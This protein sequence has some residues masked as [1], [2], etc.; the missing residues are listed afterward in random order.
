LLWFYL[1]AP[2]LPIIAG[3][4]AR[5]AGFAWA[6]SNWVL[7]AL[8]VLAFGFIVNDA[9]R[10][11]QIPTL[12]PAC[13]EDVLR[14]VSSVKPSQ[15]CTPG[16]AGIDVGRGLP[17]AGL[18]GMLM[19]LL[20]GVLLWWKRGWPWLVLGPVASAVV[21]GLP[22]TP[23]GPLNTFYGDFLSMAS[24]IWAAIHFSS[25]AASAEQ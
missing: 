12:Y 20:V 14:Y 8:G 6:Q 4:I 9:S 7:A 25:L 13:F 19:M 10:I 11:F 15:V 16:Q 24:I 2:L 3:G 21:L 17:W 23:I 18:A 1:T 22:N 5:R